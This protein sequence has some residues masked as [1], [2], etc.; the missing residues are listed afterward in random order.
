MTQETGSREVTERDQATAI[1]REIIESRPKVKITPGM[2][3]T[4]RERLKRS[5]RTKRAS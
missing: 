4:F 2:R 3:R 1:N 5:E